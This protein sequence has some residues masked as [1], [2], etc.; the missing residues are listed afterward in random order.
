MSDAMIRIV[1]GYVKLGDRR[2]LKQL[3]VHRRKLLDTLQALSGPFDAAKPIKQNNDELVIIE[4][5][6]ARLR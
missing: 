5:G 1:D 3:Q 4:A 2:A 6:I